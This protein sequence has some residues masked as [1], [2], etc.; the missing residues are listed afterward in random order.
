MNKAELIEK[1]SVKMGGPRKVA[2]EA[3][4]AITEVIT[5][6][7]ASGEPVTITGFGT[8]DVRTRAAKQ[9]RNPRTGEPVPIPEQLVVRFRPGAA[10][11]RAVK[12]E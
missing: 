12:G 1:L 10:L 4:N 2:E 7:L 5:S 8:L 11:K 3:V 9:G 6:A